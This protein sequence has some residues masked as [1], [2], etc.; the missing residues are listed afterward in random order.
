MSDPEDDHWQLDR[1]RGGLTTADIEFILGESEMQSDVATYN[2]YRSIRERVRNTILDFRLLMNHLDPQE[3]QKIFNWGGE[4]EEHEYQIG[5]VNMIAFCFISQQQPRRE[6]EPLLREG[7][8]HGVRTALGPGYT[9][10]VEFDFET[11]QSGAPKYIYKLLDKVDEN[12]FEYLTDAE[13]ETFLGLCRQAGLI[14]TDAIRERLE[15]DQEI[16]EEFDKNV[17]PG[18][19][20]DGVEEITKHLADASEQVDADAEADT[21]DL[22]E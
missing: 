7:V 16:L 3:R 15:L 10:E 22:E 2:K 17:Q 14:D 1:G 9:A 5:I 13:R 11:Q 8:R 4:E 20:I 21:D 12:G 6:F 18:D 19:E